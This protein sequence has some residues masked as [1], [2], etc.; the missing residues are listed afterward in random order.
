MVKNF[1]FLDLEGQ[2]PAFIPRVKIQE[3]FP[4]LTQKTLANLDSQ[5]KGPVFIRNGRAVIY[6]TKCL[7]GWM[8]ERTMSS[9]R[10]GERERDSAVQREGRRG[11]KKKEEEVRERRG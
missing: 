7:L 9:L 11:R 10:E 8:D 4:W 6:P 3:Y 2:F 1:K 5:G